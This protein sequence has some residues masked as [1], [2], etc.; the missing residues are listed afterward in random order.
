MGFP[1]GTLRRTGAEY[2]AQHAVWVSVLWQAFVP[3]AMIR[4]RF[5]ARELSPSE[6][7]AAYD[8][9]LREVIETVGA[10][11]VSRETD[12]DL[13]TVEAIADGESPDITLSEAVSILGLGEDLP[14]REG[15][16]VEARDILL[17]GM[18][19]AVL[20][21]EAIASGIDDALDPKE[22]QQKVEGRYPMQLDE[23][24]LLQSYIESEK[25]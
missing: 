24:A 12:I 19:T 7:R 15:I 20:D 25:P 21:V 18:S 2:D 10:E 4:D 22:I 14:D 17:M 16:L 23:Y 8:E 3:V 6:L 11:A 5:D 13:A 1:A 9:A